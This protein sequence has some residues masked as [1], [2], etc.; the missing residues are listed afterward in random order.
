MKRHILRY[1]V[2]AIIV[3]AM[4]IVA[5][6]HDSVAQ[7]TFTVTVANKTSSHPAFGEGWTEGYVIDGVQGATLT[8][9]R[10]VTY[11][12]QMQAVPSLHPFYIS[13]SATGA[14]AGVYSEGVT[15]NFATGNQ[16]LTFTPPASGPN[17]LYYQC[18]SHDSMGWRINLTGSVSADD[19]W[20]LPMSLDLEQN[21]PNPFNPSTLIRFHLSRA[22]DVSMT[23][24]DARGREVAR[25]LDAYLLSGT[26]AVGWDAT[27]GNGRPLPSGT[28]FYQVVSGPERSLR[29]MTLLR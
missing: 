2:C 11:T 17:V 16:T 18:Q 26:H 5:P 6:A 7:T 15:G 22:A 29:A 3:M 1:A 23:V 20:E 19:E 10:G 25:L 13:T 27:D 21:Y 24:F 12:F 28:Y 4:L 8:L 9:Q 14:G